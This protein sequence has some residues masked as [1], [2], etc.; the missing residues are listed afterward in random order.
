PATAMVAGGSSPREA[1][2]GGEPVA[3]AVAADAFGRAAPPITGDD[4]ARRLGILL[5]VMAHDHTPAVRHLA[6][7]SLRRFAAPGAPPGSGLAAGYD[8]SGTPADRARVVTGLRATLGSAATEPA[9]AEL[10]ARRDPSLDRDLEIG[11]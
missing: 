3:R 4:R 5:D 2:L 11:E 10:A 9:R 6:W 8:P 1:I 7:R